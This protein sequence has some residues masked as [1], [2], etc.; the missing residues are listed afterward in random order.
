MTDIFD[1]QPEMDWPLRRGETLSNHDWFPLYTHRL[2]GSDFV[3]LA[4]LDDRRADIATAL[5][6]W[7]EA[8]RQDPAGTLPADDRLLASLARFPSV[9]AWMAC[10]DGVLRGWELVNVEGDDGQFY[11]RLGHV[12]FMMKI[13]DDMYKRKRGRDA[14]N[15]ARTQAVRKSRVKDKLRE[16]GFDRFV[17]QKP[18]VN[19]ILETLD[20]GQMFITADNV[21]IVLKEHHLDSGKVTKLPDRAR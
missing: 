17:D 13:V 16:L 8:F 14:S 4:L 11:T 20:A 5:L 18:V 3:S 7:A 2:L 1:R 10:R 6:L 21:A 12:S 19:L 9:D 15:E